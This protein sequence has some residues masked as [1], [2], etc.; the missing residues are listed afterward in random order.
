MSLPMRTGEARTLMLRG[1]ELASRKRGNNSSRQPKPS[2]TVAQS[3]MEGAH[4][5]DEPAMTVD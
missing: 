3:I 5:V 4:G 2:L 1:V